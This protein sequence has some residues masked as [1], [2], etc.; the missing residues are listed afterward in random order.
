M[1]EGGQPWASKVMTWVTS[2]SGE[3]RRYKGV[4]WRGEKVW[5]QSLHLERGRLR[6]WPMMLPWPMCPL[7]GHSQLGQNVGCGSM[8]ILWCVMIPEIVPGPAADPQAH[9]F[10]PPL[11]AHLPCRCR[12]VY[13]GL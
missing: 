13:N 10:Q 12:I 5:P 4:P 6:P 2:G 3:R 7:A 8:S 9:D 1:A 11:H